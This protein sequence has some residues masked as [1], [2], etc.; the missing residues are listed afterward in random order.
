MVVRPTIGS[1]IVRLLK[2][3]YIFSNKVKENKKRK[4]ISDASNYIGLTELY[5][6]HE[7]RDDT[8]NYIDLTKFDDNH[9]PSD[10]APDL[11]LFQFNCLF[12]VQRGLTKFDDNHEPSED[13]PN[14]IDL[15]ELENNIKYKLN[16]IDLTKMGN[17]H[18]PSKEGAPDYIDLTEFDDNLTIQN[19]IKHKVFQ[20]YKRCTRIHSLKILLNNSPPIFEKLKVYYKNHFRFDDVK[21]CICGLY[22]TSSKNFHRHN[23]K[24]T[25][26]KQSWSTNE[27]LSLDII[28]EYF[29]I[30]QFYCDVDGILK[31]FPYKISPP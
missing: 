15:T 30:Q 28:F 14:Y 16:N 12:N 26:N 24:I 31:T 27:I 17:I 20:L 9:E 5:D 19:S 3:D 7:P 23:G 2:G 18:E 29:K 1:A 6:N 25:I 13:A 10:D 22:H 21:R 11:R 8:P 4:K